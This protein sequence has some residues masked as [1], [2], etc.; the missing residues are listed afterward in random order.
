MVSRATLAKIEAFK[1][2]M[3]WQFKWVSSFGS[4]F[5]YDYHVS[6]TPQ[7]RSKGKVDY[8]YRV[9]EFPS[10]E[11][12]GLS[13]FYKDADTGEIFHTYSTYA[14]GLEQLMATYKVL[15]LV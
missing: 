14:R 6:F 4:D 7:E 3:G 12:P 5:N 2:R 10:E 11:G 15:D 8:N 1:K 13:V 9:E